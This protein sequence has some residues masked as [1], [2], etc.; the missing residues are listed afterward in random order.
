MHNIFNFGKITLLLCISLFSIQS[1]ADKKLNGEEITELLSNKTAIGFFQY[2]KSY[3]Y[4][5]ENGKT[6][7]Q[8]ETNIKPDPG[9]WKVKNNQYCSNWGRFNSCY[10][11]TENTAQ[12]VYYFSTKTFKTP[13]IIKDGNQLLPH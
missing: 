1:F 8:T 11:I 9:T 2:K 4:F 13:F 3:Q 5:D 6:L 10:D 7:W 12:G